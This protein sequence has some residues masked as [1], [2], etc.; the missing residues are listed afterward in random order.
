MFPQINK[1]K[2]NKPMEKWAKNMNDSKKR[3]T[4]D[5]GTHADMLGLVIR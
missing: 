2:I 3:A 1:K 5:S 4:D